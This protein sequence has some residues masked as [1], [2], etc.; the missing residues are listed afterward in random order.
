MKNFKCPPEYCS[1]GCASEVSAQRILWF[2]EERSCNKTCSRFLLKLIC[3]SKP[4][5]LC[6]E[7]CVCVCVFVLVLLSWRFAFV[8]VYDYLLLFNSLLAHSLCSDLAIF[9]HKC[10]F[11][12]VFFILI[13]FIISVHFFVFN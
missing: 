4:C 5:S 6:S 11:R 1:F 12:K 7:T 13:Y 10:F 3:I 9:L 2:K 8:S